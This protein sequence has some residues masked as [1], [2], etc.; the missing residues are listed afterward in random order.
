MPGNP[1]CGRASRVPHTV[2]NPPDY[3][4]WLGSLNMLDTGAYEIAL[5]DTGLG[6]GEAGTLH[7]D[8]SCST[9]NAAGTA[10]STPRSI[11]WQYPTGSIDSGADQHDHGTMVAGV[12]VGNPGVGT[13]T[14]LSPQDDLGQRFFFG[15]GVAPKTGII[16]QKALISDW[17][18]TMVQWLDRAKSAGAS[19]LTS[20]RNEYTDDE[21]AVAGDYTTV[22]QDFDQAILNE[23]IPITASVGN[24]YPTSGW[25]CPWGSGCDSATRTVV[26]SPALAKNVISLG[27]TEGYKTNSDI[28]CS[29]TNTIPTVWRN[30]SSLNDV[31][32]FSR[33]GAA[34]TD[35]RIKPELVAPSSLITSTKSNYSVTVGTL[36]H[37]RES[38]MPD[39]T[40]THETSSGTSFAAPQAAAAA[41][42]VNKW[43]G[44]APSNPISASG[45]KAVLVGTAK[46]LYGTGIDRNTGLNV[47]SRPDRTTGQGF[48]RLYLTNLFNNVGIDR[49]SDKLTISSTGTVYSS[50]FSKVYSS[51][52]TIVVLAWN[53]LINT[54][55]TPA[56]L[57]T[58]LDLEVVAGG[59]SYRGNGLSGDVSLS[60]T[61]YDS[62]NNTEIVV[63]PYDPGTT[64]FTVNV[65]GTQVP[66]AT[67]Y[68]LY[69][70]NG[71]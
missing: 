55:S 27:G 11:T 32:F 4:A 13:S 56:S 65:R 26:L 33:R 24:I 15:M 5:Y 50:S 68:S 57:I 18:D 48:G 25:T 34:G 46:S 70:V 31:A 37:C 22:D 59:E 54:G 7:A 51:G 42:I 43:F 44:Y 67:N 3:R 38:G 66:A 58:N 69:V 47:Y 60:Y 39:P 20:S 64:T 30:A 6:D 49:L 35:A 63:L 28:V 21:V 14:T 41:V 53:D 17:Q 9:W 71:Y 29:S 52:Q 12:A 16:V 45:I 8:L 19:V 2:T 36:R 23:N 10:C 61:S 62:V 1:S 40:T